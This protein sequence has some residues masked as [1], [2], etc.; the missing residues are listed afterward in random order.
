MTHTIHASRI[1]WPIHY[2]ERTFGRYGC[3][4]FFDELPTYL[5]A[6]VIPKHPGRRTLE[7]RPDLSDKMLCRI[8][9][10]FVP[11]ITFENGLDGLRALA[12]LQEL[13]KVA[14]IG[15]NRLFHDI[16]A[17]LAVH[18]V[19]GI[20]VVTLGKPQAVKRL[21]IV[22]MRCNIDHVMENMNRLLTECFL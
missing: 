15:P 17:T 9:Q 14:N 16:P 5:Q 6:H 21:Q 18:P 7:I 12:D 11:R 20:D 10:P 8:N 19:E 2:P 4:V 13:A 22:A 1:M 3:T